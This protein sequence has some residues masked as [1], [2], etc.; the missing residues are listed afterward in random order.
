MSSPSNTAVNLLREQCEKFLKGSNRPCGEPGQRSD[1]AEACLPSLPAVDTQPN[2]AASF[3]DMPPLEDTPST[4]EKK[5]APAG[6][7]SPEKTAIP[8]ETI[9]KAVRGAKKLIGQGKL[10]D[11]QA[12]TIVTNNLLDRFDD[13]EQETILDLAGQTRTESNQ[14][15]GILLPAALE[16][17]RN[18]IQQGNLPRC[19]A[20]YLARWL[21]QN[22]MGRSSFSDDELAKIN[23]AAGTS[24]QV[25]ERA[26]G[27]SQKRKRPDED[28][29]D[30][31]RLREEDQPDPKRVR[32]RE[33][34][35][36]EVEKSTI[37]S[38]PTGDNTY[39]ISFK[40]GR[41]SYQ[42]VSQTNP[43][44]LESETVEF[45]IIQKN[46]YASYDV[47][48]V[49]P[50]N[51]QV[52]KENEAKQKQENAQNRQQDI[53]N[54][55]GRKAIVIADSAYKHC[56]DRDSGSSLIG[57]LD[58]DQTKTFANEVLQWV[59]NS[60]WNGEEKVLEGSLSRTFRSNC[61]ISEQG[62]YCGETSYQISLHLTGCPARET[63]AFTIGHH[64]VVV[65]HV[66]PGEGAHNALVR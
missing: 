64:A 16:A 41:I 22:A 65:H 24:G 50:D 29:E 36:V 20:Q 47:D 6:Q 55:M 39:K 53:R 8:E 45:K 10:N 43:L 62:L 60:I 1:G 15:G 2:T 49:I 66:G 61:T 42:G 23:L 56:R 4:E 57:H 3:N 48:L 33:G 37:R 21:Q 30:G 38:I 13:K 9:A 28:R 63:L 54:S 58:K 52:A 7:P 19:D 35:L 40:L 59:I 27:S 26:E 34:A 46:D 11:S 44:N 31:P 14:Q 18:R 32:P 5:E 25:A 12:Q 51:V 17:I